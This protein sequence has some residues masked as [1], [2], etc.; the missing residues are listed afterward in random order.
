M[1]VKKTVDFYD[2]R[3]NAWGG[4]TDTLD[5]IEDKGKEQ[6]FMD[7]LEELYPD[8]TNETELN[9]FI[10]FNDDYIFK[11][12]DISSEEDD[13]NEYDDESAEYDADYGA[14]YSEEEED[15]E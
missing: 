10:A 7:L 1:I 2:I 4:A 13:D 14:D 6:E 15:D 5:T 3:D 11:C 9:D 8:G 12:L